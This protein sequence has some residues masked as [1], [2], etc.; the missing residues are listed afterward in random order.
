M[1]IVIDK[2]IYNDVFSMEK[3]L[4][5]TIYLE[6]WIYFSCKQKLFNNSYVLRDRDASI[7]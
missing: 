6:K 2:K 1:R 7:R 5:A 3:L 4:C